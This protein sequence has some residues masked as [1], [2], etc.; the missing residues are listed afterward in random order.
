MTTQVRTTIYQQSFVN[1]IIEACLKNQKKCSVLASLKVLKP[2]TY[3]KEEVCREIQVHAWRLVL[4]VSN[5]SWGM[6]N[7][8]Q[9]LV[10]RDISSF[11]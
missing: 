10:Q 1:Q 6:W 2:K 8:L 11:P 9:K 7:Q 3:I 4:K 5:S